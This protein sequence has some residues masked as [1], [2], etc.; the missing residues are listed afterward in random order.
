MLFFPV[1]ADSRPTGLGE[2]VVIVLAIEEGEKD[3]W[4]NDGTMRS[5]LWGHSVRARDVRPRDDHV[6]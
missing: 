1:G 2:D 3:E 4:K 5:Q 6:T